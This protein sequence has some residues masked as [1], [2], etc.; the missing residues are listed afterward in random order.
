MLN[1]IT[2]ELIRDKIYI[3]R[4]KKVMLD[5]DL[6]MIYGY[7]TKYLNRQVKRNIERFE[8]E[9]FMFQLTAEEFLRC[10]NGTSK[11]E[12]QGG[13]RYRPYVFTEQGIYMLMTVLRGDLAIKQSRA[14]IRAFKAM[15]DYIFENSIILNQR[16]ELRTIA[17]ITTNSEK[18]NKVEG[19]I[20]A[21][22]QRLIE[23]EKKAEKAIMR[24]EISPILLDFNSFSEHQEYLLMNGELVKAKEI[25]QTIYSRAKSKIY[26]L[27]DYI[28]IRTLRLL[29]KA[30]KNVE[31]IIFSDNVCHYLHESDYEDF[32]L[33]YPDK[34]IKFIKTCG[35]LHDRFIVIDYKTKDEMIY[36]SGASSKDAGKSITT[37]MELKTELTRKSMDAIV[38]MLMCNPELKLK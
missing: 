15:K 34:N 1:R 20:T 14:L 24:D 3:I 12:G 10:Q 27:D 35:T 17:L 26:I 9:D 25:Y 16:E 19:E 6:A 11:K 13:K 4:G 37:I 36:H 31:I 32:K 29:S 2:S 22:D 30:R 33:E 18:L 7:D 8:G 21:M 28:D 38:D 23:V 5:Y